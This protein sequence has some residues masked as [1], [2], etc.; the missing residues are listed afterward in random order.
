MDI[1]TLNTSVF[2]AGDL[3]LTFTDDQ[4]PLLATHLADLLAAPGVQIRDG[5]FAAG[6]QT[7]TLAPHQAALLREQWLATAHRR[8]AGT[9]AQLSAPPLSG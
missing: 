5:V 7:L 3:R 2:V 8:A 9:R 4:L 6:E 1:D